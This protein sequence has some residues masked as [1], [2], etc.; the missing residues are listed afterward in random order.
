MS[1]IIPNSRL[2]V[3]NPVHQFPYR[4]D[5]FQS[6][7][8]YAIQ[9]DNNVLITAHTAAGKTTIAEYAIALSIFLG[10]KVLYTSP[11]KTLS[12]QKY[13]DFETT[14]GNVGILTGDIKLNPEA[15]I[16]VLTTEILRNKL[17]HELN[18]FAD[19]HCVIFDE[20]HYF[21]DP[22]RGFV[23]EECITK[24]P[25]HVLLVMLSATI[26][27]AEE[28]A[29]WV[30]S[31][32]NR[33][34]YLIGTNWRPVPL[35]HYV[36]TKDEITMVNKHKTGLLQQKLD[37]VYQYYGQEKITKHRLLGLSSFLGKNNLFP[38]ICFSFSRKK[39]VEY[40]TMLK[41]GTPYLS[42]EEIKKTK[43]IIHKVFST[44]LHFYKEIPSTVE[45][46]E[47]LEHGLAIHHSGLLPIQKELVEI[48]FSHGLIK[49]LFATETFAVGVN[50]PTKTVVFTELSKYDG[51]SDFPR[52]LRYDEFMQMSGRA[53]RRGKDDQGYVIYCP[54]RNLEEKHLVIGLF[55]GRAA[56]L[57]SQYDEG[58]NTF[59]R[60]LNTI[61]ENEEITNFYKSTLFGMESVKH[62]GQI[63]AELE[64]LEA[65]Y[66]AIEQE[67]LTE[68][69]AKLVEQYEKLQI[70][71]E[72]AGSKQ[73]VKIN[74]QLDEL[75]RNLTKKIRD[76]ITLVEDK[77]KMAA[78]IT[79]LQGNIENH[80]NSIETN[81][82]SVADF[83]E[84]LELI[85]KQD[86]KMIITSY[87]KIVASLSNCSEIVLGK[88]VQWKL[89]DGAS[90]RTI[91]MVLS[92]FA[93]D[94]KMMDVSED[95]IWSEVS[96]QLDKETTGILDE[97]WNY[98]LYILEVYAENNLSHRMLMSF[99]FI[100]PFL[101]WLDR[102]PL[103]EILQKFDG[104]DGNFVKAIYKIRDMC[105]E[106]LK[107]CDN[108]NLGELQEKINVLLE[109]L[110]Y[111]IGEFNSLY[112]HHYQLIKNL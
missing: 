63:Q 33:N 42:Q 21:N 67:D 89:L 85:K 15:N 109:N 107:V 71:F 90:W 37:Q 100:E 12:N 46:L 8:C 78:N 97:I 54:L 68:E 41:R 24:L 86:G 25:K 98:Y 93:L 40:C 17:D 64:K 69:E 103:I 19:I 73:K 1:V 95:D 87:G 20:V 9:N 29:N 26:D 6:N 16:I 31:C 59:L 101:M 44:N 110:I 61:S 30:V 81:I 43:L 27:K 83:N 84:K 7:G 4:L 39:C 50:M 79:S 72:N 28:F 92:C 80:R 35:H 65:K 66:A 23:W 111:G 14:F 91:G 105:Q 32:R 48:L 36:Y 60:L 56:K 76:W 2:E 47:F 34:C 22:E 49:F 104:F 51:S 75:E 88:V 18:Q 82:D 96:Q 11:I 106:L 53:G 58:A 102:K 62:I 57:C 13:F 5:D 112:I 77:K 108:F 55:K 74:K 52:I 10:K 38:A 94:K 45:L 3:N 99:E 70:S